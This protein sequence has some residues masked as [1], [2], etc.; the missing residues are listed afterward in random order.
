MYHAGKEP[1]YVKISKVPHAKMNTCCQNR[2]GSA[3]VPPPVVVPS[4]VVSPPPTIGQPPI[5][6]SQLA[7]LPQPNFAKIVGDH[8]QIFVHCENIALEIAKYNNLPIVQAGNNMMNMLERIEWG[9]LTDR[10]N[11]NVCERNVL[12]NDDK[13][14]LKTFRNVRDNT[15]ILYF[16]LTLG[17]LRGVNEQHLNDILDAL[18]LDGLET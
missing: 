5:V 3:I 2:Q 7:V 12:V 6:V 14:R 13:A 16:P 8:R 4:L 1:L 17:K 10:H 9:L 18:T 15:E 11:H